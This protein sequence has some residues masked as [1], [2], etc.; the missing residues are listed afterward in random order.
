MVFFRW[1]VL[2][3]FLKQKLKWCQNKQQQ[4]K[5]DRI[6]SLH[7]DKNFSSFWKNTKKLNPRTALPVSVG[8]ENRPSQIANI[9]KKHFQVDPP[10][11]IAGMCDT[12]SQPWD[13]SAK[14]TAKDMKSI[15]NNMVRGKSPGHDDF[16]IEH[17]QSAGV[18][19]PRF[20]SMFF[21]LCL[22]HF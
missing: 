19:L 13:V 17:L 18:H 3:K 12:D 22:R 20:L 14:F 6:A 8:G 11:L 2:E 21:N 7:S 10:N 16:S 9:F 4:I 1:V 5:L 15:I